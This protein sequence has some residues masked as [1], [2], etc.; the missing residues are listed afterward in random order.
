MYRLLVHVEG[1]TEENFVDTV[2]APHLYSRGFTSVRARLLGNARQRDR[3]GGIRPWES[4]RVDILSHLTQDQATVATTMVDYY[5][6][7]ETWP[8]RAKAKGKKTLTKRART[9][10][11]AIANDIV[12]SMSDA[13]DHRRFVPYV[14]MHEF[15][16]L[17]FS[18]P[19]R[20]AWA[21]GKPNLRAELQTIRKEF[22]TPEHINE[23]PES[24]PSRR[25][26]DLYEGF[27][28]PLMGV[29]A[30]QKT[31]LKDIRSECRLFDK[32]VRKLEERV[33]L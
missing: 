28:K 18:D 9:V 16:G 21:M 30:A 33:D 8:G 13:F 11:R 10:E 31:G 2:L 15:E 6:L 1:Q 19:D 12:A 23:S 17:L 7:P 32:W 3:R 24:H 14:V 22:S 26:R 27:Q 5:G 20:L 25:I 4:V 29:L